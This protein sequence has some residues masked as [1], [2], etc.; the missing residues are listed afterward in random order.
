MYMVMECGSIDLASF[1]RKE[2]KN[3]AMKEEDIKSYW[4]QMLEAVD[5]IHK[6][7]IIHSDLKPANFLFVDAK[8]KLIDFGI[9]NAI[10]QDHTS[11]IRESQVGTLNY[12]SPE[13]IQDT[14]PTPHF[15]AR[16]LRKPRLKINCKSDVWSLGCILYYI[17]YGKT[18]FQHITNHFAKLQAICDPMHQIQ[19]PDTQHKML[20]DIL[21][22]SSVGD[23]LHYDRVT[24]ISLAAKMSEEGLSRR[25]SW[26]AN[27][28]GSGSSSSSSGSK[29]SPCEELN[30]VSSLR[31]SAILPVNDEKDDTIPLQL[32]TTA[33]KNTAVREHFQHI[34]QSASKSIRGSVFTPDAKPSLNLAA[35]VGPSRAS[36][37]SSMF[38]GAIRL[39]R[40]SL[41]KVCENPGYDD[42]DND[43]YDMLHGIKPLDNDN[44]ITPGNDSL[45][46]SELTPDHEAAGKGSGISFPSMVDHLHSKSRVSGNLVHVQGRQGTLSSISESPVCATSINTPEVPKLLS[47]MN[48]ENR[49]L[50][51]SQK[52]CADDVEMCDIADRSVERCALRQRQPIPFPQLH[53]DSKPVHEC[54]NIEQV[55]PLQQLVFTPQ[56]ANPAAVHAS[57]HVIMQPMQMTSTIKKDILVVNGRPYNVLRVIGKGGSSKVYQVFDE[58]KKKLYAIKDVNLEFADEVIVQG[59]LNEISLLGKLQNSDRIIHLY[60]Q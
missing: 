57:N 23:R 34:S 22:E 14:S 51:Q 5:C 4:R 28:S 18:P 31:S 6:Q 52:A 55:V 20:I 37:G 2:S 56:Y 59:Y 19:F 60:D 11:V 1:L 54:K 24:G 26:L 33:Q 40:T 8:L 58:Q 10:Q 48:S 7:G 21:K 27:N 41:P 32:P 25:G 47:V 29:E 13:A 35:T 3:R 42:D 50:L 43:D 16:G 9:A 53:S 17:V 44:Q 36:R 30:T 45:L 39:K 15:D 46:R 12:M 38:G 49:A